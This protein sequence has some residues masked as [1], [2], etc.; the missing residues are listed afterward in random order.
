MLLLK[1]PKLFR[2]EKKI[3]K[4]NN[5][6]NLPLYKSQKFFES[7]DAIVYN[8]QLEEDLYYFLKINKIVHFNEQISK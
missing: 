7:M 2:K 6:Q 8:H 1:F 4:L 5:F 3:K